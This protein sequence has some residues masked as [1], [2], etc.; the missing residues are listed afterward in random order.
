[1]VRLRIGHHA[2]RTPGA[3]TAAPPPQQG[4]APPLGADVIVLGTVFATCGLLTAGYA[5]TV[6][7]L[8]AV[9]LESGEQ[10]RR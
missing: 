9:S 6:I 8:M 7:L 4:S 1:M 3:T 10:D 5:A 2:H